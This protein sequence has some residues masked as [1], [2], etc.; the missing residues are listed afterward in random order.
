M[1]CWLSSWVSFTG[2]EFPILFFAAPGCPK[3][4]FP[5]GSLEPAAAGADPLLR[6]LWS[7]WQADGYCWHLPFSCLSVLAGHQTAKL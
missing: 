4:G 3:A 7:P 5:V 1:P 2:Q 6:V